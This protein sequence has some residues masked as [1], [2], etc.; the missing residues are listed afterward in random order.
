MYSPLEVTKGIFYT[1]VNDR[2][3]HLFENLWPLPNGVSYNS[4]LIADEKCALV[5]TVDI[6]YSD[7]FFQKVS[8]VIGSKPIDYLIVN[9]MEPDHSGSIEW[10]LSK[11]PHIRIVG[12]KR[13]VEMLKG[14]YGVETE[15]L[16]L[17]QDL[18]ELSL[19]NCTLKFYLTPMVHW[20]ET[21][22]TYVKEQKTL[23][24]GDAFGTFGAL[25]GG[26]LDCQL[27][28]ERYRDEMIRYYSNIVGKFG[29]PV[30]TALKKL[31]GIEIDII[32]STHGPVWTQKENIAE[33]VGLYDRLSRY[34]ADPGL[35]IAY[36]SM[37]GHTEQ[38]AEIIAAAAAEQGLRNIV[39]H[40][41]SKSHESDILRDVFAYKGLIIGS[42]TYNNKLYPAVESLI[43]GL[44]NRYLKN[45]FF[46]CFG[47]F[48]WSDATAKQL[49]AF[50]ESSEFEM[51][52]EPVVMKQAMLEDVV[53][54]AR[55][56]GKTM[57]GKLLS[58][59]TIG[60]NDRENCH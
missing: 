53:E 46:G 32:C 56:L 24:S 31:S 30:Q 45:R 18:E 27:L 23:F 6:C 28:P 1:G 60:P 50:A 13:T 29:S 16:L 26:V 35:V 42:P 57:A 49:T 36:G 51:V 14:Y 58:G 17:I 39:I 34:E 20:P 37:Y 25:N 55:S 40:N 33:V 19:G 4:Y 21:M 10:L 38:L 15:N 41:V 11:Y 5:D 7:L 43:S 3:K 54:K 9:H 2:T 59:D 22:M 52:G 47:S 44:Q 8:A 12:N 48:S